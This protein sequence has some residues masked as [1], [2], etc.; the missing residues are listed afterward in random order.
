MSIA[1]GQPDTQ[2]EQGTHP[3]T[4]NFQGHAETWG[5]LVQQPPECARL[6]RILHHAAQELWDAC[7]GSNTDY[8]RTEARA[9][10]RRIIAACHD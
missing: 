10:A 6:A 5:P 1:T 9:V 4:G 8:M 3:T 7:T 2:D